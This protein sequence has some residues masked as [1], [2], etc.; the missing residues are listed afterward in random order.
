MRAK[1]IQSCPTLVTL[2]TIAC[3]APLSM[4]FSRQD[5]QNGLPC[6]PP[7]DLP[8]S[9]IKHI[10]LTSPA[11]AGGLFTI[12]ATWETH[13]GLST[14]T[15]DRIRIKAHVA[16]S[17]WLSNQESTCR[18]PLPWY[19]FWKHLPMSECLHG[20][21]FVLQS[22]VF[23]SFQYSVIFEGRTDNGDGWGCLPSHSQSP[24]HQRPRDL[25]Q[26]RGHINVV[27]NSHQK[28]CISYNI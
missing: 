14:W 8:D 3:Q 12:S 21:E 6:P 23:D 9:G 7:R 10:S 22:L 19:V 4:G 15:I 5:Y 24:P 11:L 27:A 18:V 25:T 28:W 13:L 1:S 16:V 17:T 2:W 26:T 20:T